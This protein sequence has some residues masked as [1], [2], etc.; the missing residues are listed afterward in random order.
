MS[1]TK[2]QIDENIDDFILTGGSRTRAS[3]LRS[4]LKQIT[5]GHLNKAEGGTLAAPIMAGGQ[6]SIDT[7]NRRLR[8]SSGIQTLSWQDHTMFDSNPILS[9]DW[10]GRFLYKNDSGAVKVVSW[11]TSELTEGNTVKLNWENGSLHSG[12]STETLNWN[13]RYTKDSS[14][15]ISLSWELRRLYRSD[16]SLAYDWEINI[17]YDNA[18]VASVDWNQ[19]QLYNSALSPTLDWQNYALRNSSNVT[20]L[21]WENRLLINDWIHKGSFLGDNPLKGLGYTTGS[22]GTVT[23][24]TSKTTGVTLNK[25]TGQITT[26][27]ESMGQHDIKVFVVSNTAISDKDVILFSHISG[28]T[29]GDYGFEACGLVD[30]TSFSIAI[31][32]FSTGTSS[33]ALVFNF[34]IIKGSNS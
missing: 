7:V 28:G 2:A 29:T 11:N 27:N 16:A 32:K 26:H 21:N 30:A 17:A 4:I 3:N 24:L 9:V 6:I 33:D 19:R 18:G 14:G 34:A 15:E 31:K 20:V 23:Q 13:S 5:D 12:S 22:G 8:N 10:S 1:L 25:I